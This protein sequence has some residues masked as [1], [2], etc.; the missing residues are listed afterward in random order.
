MVKLIFVKGVHIRK[1][2]LDLEKVRKHNCSEVDE[3]CHGIQGGLNS[4]R[5]GKEALILKG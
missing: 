5:K 4:G 1:T 2:V 3:V